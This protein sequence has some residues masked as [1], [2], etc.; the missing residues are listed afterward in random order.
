MGKKEKISNDTFSER[1]QVA[2]D[3]GKDFA[4]K[5]N[6]CVLDPSMPIATDSLALDKKEL[7][8]FWKTNNIRE[9]FRRL[10]KRSVK[11]KTC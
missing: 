7:S 4:S 6:V 5:A 9:S 10:G 1:E 11:G 2:H 8:D 3:S